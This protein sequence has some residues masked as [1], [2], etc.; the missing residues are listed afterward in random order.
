MP[1]LDT[2]VIVRQCWGCN[3]LLIPKPWTPGTLALLRLEGRLVYDEY[4]CDH[5]D[6]PANVLARSHRA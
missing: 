6:C 4:L 3:R 1:D 2:R 5:A